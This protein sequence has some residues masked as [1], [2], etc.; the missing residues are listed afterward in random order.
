MLAAA[1]PTSTIVIVS[2]SEV[3]VVLRGGA[4]SPAPITPATIASIAMCS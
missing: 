4:V 1:R 3:W 2:S